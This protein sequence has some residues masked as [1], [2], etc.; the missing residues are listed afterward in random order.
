V[1]QR[2]DTPWRA[3]LTSDG[4]RTVVPLPSEAELADFYANT[5]FQQ[6][7]TT[8]YSHSYSEE[9]LAHR[10]ARADLIVHVARALLVSSAGP[11]W[12]LDVGFGEGFE[13]AAARSAGFA[14]H[15]VDFGVDG[16]LRCH[17]E[18]E[19]SVEVGDPVAALRGFVSNGRRFDV[20]ILKNVIEH[21]LEPVPYLRAIARALTDDGLAVVT[22][23]NDY[24]ALQAELMAQGLVDRE[25]WF[26]PPQ[27]LQYFN[28]DNLSR[29]AATADFEVIDVIGDFPI[30]LFLLHPGSNYVLQPANGPAAHRA[31]VVTDLLMARRGLESHAAA[32]RALASTGLSRTL[33]AYLRR[34]KS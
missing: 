5:Y 20:C 7:P 33:T 28:A 26:T 24:S 21:V 31:R 3:V 11:R 34:R 23:P 14:V 6:L 4:Y 27:H 29:F 1:S 22:V 30:E 19:S 13:L 16:L 10:R 2:K 32:C 25:Y 15:G 9:E 18:L 12:L 17:P 8:T